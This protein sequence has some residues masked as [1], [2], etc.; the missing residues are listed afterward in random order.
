M[1]TLLAP[2]RMDG[3]IDAAQLELLLTDLESEG[4]QEQ[5]VNEVL[6]R[7][8][9]ERKERY[10][11]NLREMHEIITKL[12]KVSMAQDNRFQASLARDDK[13]DYTYSQSHSVVLML[14]TL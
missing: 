11:D 1:R 5:D 3:T 14:I 13:V 2:L 10:F 9:G 12:A 6:S 7:R 8:L 4:W